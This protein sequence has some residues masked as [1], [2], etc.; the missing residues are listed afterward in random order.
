MVPRQAEQWQL[1]APLPALRRPDG[2]LQLGLEPPAGLIVGRLPPRAEKVIDALLKPC[3]PDRIELIA[4]PASRQWLPQ[5]LG[6]LERA[7]LL[8]RSIPPSE[9]VTV[10]GTGRLALLVTRLLLASIAEPVRVVWPG[11]PD[12]PTVLTRLLKQHSNRL[13]VSGHTGGE[14]TGLVLVCA[15]ALEPDRAVLRQVGG[16]AQL[17]VC[18]TD[19]GASVGPLVVPGRTPCLR[20]EDLHRARRDPAWPELLLQLS[21]PR[22]V[23]APVPDLHWAAGLAVLHAACWLA[24]GLPDSLGA[25]LALDAERALRMRRLRPHPGCGCGAVS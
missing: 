4:G 14:E 1:T 24:G 16:R 6:A 25:T 5:L 10:V 22:P 15:R 18:G 7:G 3:E 21:R 11:V 23:D 20:C 9:P 2:V 17:V 19:L 13:S 8:R 12:T